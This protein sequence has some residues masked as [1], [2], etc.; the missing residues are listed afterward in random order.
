MMHMVKI[1]RLMVA[2]STFRMALLLAAVTLQ[3]HTWLCLLMVG[4]RIIQFPK[5]SQ[6]AV[7]L[8]YVL[9][10]SLSFLCS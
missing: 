6:E 7:L 1:L 9:H 3:T 2:V 8:H 10:Y 4:L 5:C